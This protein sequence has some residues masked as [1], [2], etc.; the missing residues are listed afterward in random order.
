MRARVRG[1]YTTAVTRRLLDAGHDVVQ[2]S[3]PIRDRFDAAFGF[4]PADVAVAT[5]ADRQGVGVSGD[6]DAVDALREDLVGVAVDALS[7]EDRAP[8]G[9]VF[10]GLVSDELGSGAIV[11]LGD[12]EAFLPYDDADGYVEAG[13]VRRVQ[14]VDAAPPWGDDRPEVAESLRVDDG[15]V[16]LDRGRSGVSANVRG[17]RATELVRTTELLQRD[18]P[19]GWGVRWQRAAADA[20][21][22]SLGDALAAASERARALDDLPAGDPDDAPVRLD[23]DREG[24]ATPATAWVWFGRTARFALDDDRRRVATTMPGHHRVKAGSASAS[25]AVDFAEGVLAHATDGDWTDATGDDADADADGGELPFPAVVDA[26]GPRDGGTLAIEHGKPEGR[27]ITLGRGRITDLDVDAG[28]LTLERDMTGGGTYDA[29]GV[30]REDG[31]VAVTKLTEG[32]WWYPTVY[33]SADGEK[34]GTYV[35]VCTPVELFPDGARYVDLHVDVVRHADGSVE[36]VDDDE[37]DDAVD[38]GHVA[39]AL[40]DRARTVASSVERAL[41]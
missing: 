13:D 39:P 8:L 38:V 10:L 22:G 7:W 28:K 29:L 18:A 19:D 23:T 1:I 20:D 32:K 15:L 21:M 11:D 35:N 41:R 36:R 14:V 4:A 3:P 6:L 30:A 9:A 25:D 33:R 12:T 34:K 26:F 17:E 16:A 2:A 40:A 5:S 27:R 24:V 37:L 31:D